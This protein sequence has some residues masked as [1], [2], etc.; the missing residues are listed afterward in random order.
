MKIGILSDYINHIKKNQNKRQ[1]ENEAQFL[2]IVTSTHDR[3]GH[4]EWEGTLNAVRQTIRKHSVD[5]DHKMNE[6]I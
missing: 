2:A 5:L 3:Q 4:S 6:R 1:E